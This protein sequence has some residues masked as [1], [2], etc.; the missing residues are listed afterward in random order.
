MYFLMITMLEN[1]ELKIET[2]RLYNNRCNTKYFIT[3]IAVLW[4][5][6]IGC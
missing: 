2:K 1:K 4:K 6:E 3:K 5:F